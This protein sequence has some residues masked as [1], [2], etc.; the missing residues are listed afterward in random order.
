MNVGT[1]LSSQI[2]A[3]QGIYHRFSE[4]AL[5]NKTRVALKGDGGLGEVFTYAQL[6]ASCEALAA[7]LSSPEHR[8]QHVIGILSEN[9]PEWPIIYLAILRSGKTAVPIDAALKPEEITHIT[10]H[11]RLKT[12]FVSSKLRPNTVGL[13][14]SIRLVPVDSLK[15]NQHSQ[16]T[17]EC[18]SINEIAVLIY[19]SGTTGSPKAVMLT[20]L[21]ILSNLEAIARGLAFSKEDV[22]LSVLPLHHTFEATCGF[23]TPLMAGA[24]IVYARSLKSKEILEDIGVNRVRVMCGVPL[25][26]EKMYHSITRKISEAPV[27]RQILFRTLFSLSKLGW[28]FGQKWGRSLFRS[29]RAK[30]GLSSARMFVSGGAPLPQIVAEFFNLLGFD[31]FQ[32][33]GMTECSPV[34]SMN[35]PGAIQFGSVGEPLDNLQVRIDAPVSGQPGEICV[36][37]PSVTPGYLGLAELTAQT[38]REGWLHTGDLGQFKRGHLWITGRAKNVIITGAGKNIY[39]EELEEKLLA[40]KHVMEAVVFGRSRVGKTGEEPVTI[41]VPDV[42]QFRSEEPTEGKE[43][44]LET[45]SSVLR[46]WVAEVNGQVAEYK[47]IVD[48]TVQMQELEKTSTKKIKRYLYGNSTGTSSTT[49]T[50]G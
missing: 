27:V 46:K 18:E 6:S 15:L 41:L 50:Q 21:N 22:F 37:G 19:T 36:K 24:S 38:V 40:S 39:P 9:R 8:E 20:H 43:P 48:V 29:L 30:A 2:S 7:E 47:R 1:G 42:E 13:D 10:S 12:L 49:Q 11:S 23:L 17:A 34:I 5:R 16:P 4:S 44:S 33:Y 31:F 28:M 32:G 25:L 35:R 26:Y 3:D 14:K 45:M